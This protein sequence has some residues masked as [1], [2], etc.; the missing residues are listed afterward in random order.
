MLRW[1]LRLLLAAV[2]LSAVGFITNAYAAF[3]VFRVL[4]GLCLTAGVL[5]LVVWYV[6]APRPPEK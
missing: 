2:V 6:R 1:A 4:G 3:E 5:M